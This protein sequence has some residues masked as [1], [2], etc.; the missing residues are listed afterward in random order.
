MPQ[1]LLRVNKPSGWQ[2]IYGGICVLTTIQ[3]EPLKITNW[4]RLSVPAICWLSVSL[5]TQ[6]DRL[7]QV[8]SLLFADEPK[9]WL[10]MEWDWYCERSNASQIDTGNVACTL[11][12]KKRVY[13]I[14]ACESLETMNPGAF[15]QSGPG[16]IAPGQAQAWAHLVI[17]SYSTRTVLSSFNFSKRL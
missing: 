6:V 17:V 14:L 5:F 4:N 2:Q 15:L 3:L 7:C 8:A 10:H 13:L 16:A 1:K 12:P 11:E 9:M